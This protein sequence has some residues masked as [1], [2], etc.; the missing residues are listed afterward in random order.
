MAI[1]ISINQ[2][3]IIMQWFYAE[4]GKQQ[5]PVEFEQL[6]ALAR[7]G[8]VKPGEPVWNASMGNQWAKAGSVPDLF[9]SQ[10][11]GLPG[12]GEA[13]PD[14]SDTATFKSA[15]PNRELN[16]RAR[17]A[18]DGNWGKAIGGLVVYALILV[19][20]AFIPFLGSA[21]SFVISG[22]LMVGVTLF[23]LNLAR[24]KPAEISQ[25]FDGF[26]VFGNAFVAYL[27]IMLLI[28]AWSL[29]AV[30]VGI[31]V[32]IGLVMAG[33]KGAAGGDL[34]ALGWMA[35]LVPLVF[36]AL[37]PAIIAQFRY[38]Q[39][40]YLLCDVP[41]IGPLVAIQRSTQ[42]MVGNKWKLFCLQCRFI[43]WAL[44]CIPTLGIGFLW[45]IPYMTVSMAAF[46][47]DV[48]EG[49]RN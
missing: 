25:L 23:Y 15:T 5:G 17:T 45:L 3:Y 42:M 7:N 4:N 29:P 32:G 13:I 11:P 18:L 36:V 26:K 37:I 44:L 31:A 10:L 27:L 41:G 6:V 28:L 8:N 34:A 1:P 9:E 16:T 22:P 39:T 47:D 24:Q 49:I 12:D 2:E 21:I 40:Y 43:G 35:V 20:L 46:Y 48:K 30:V 33:V 14:W 38:S 19:V